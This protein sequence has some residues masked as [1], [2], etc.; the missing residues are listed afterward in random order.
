VSA[1]RKAASREEALAELSASFKGMQ[2]AYRRLRGRETQ[3]HDALSLAQ[4]QLLFGLVDRD[5]SA[6]DL[7]AAADLSPATVTQMLDYLVELGLVERAR[8]EH[9]RR[10]VLS[11]LT[12][13][14][15]SAVAERREHH[16]RRWREAL[17]DLDLDEL[18]A[19]AVVLDRLHEL[20]DGYSVTE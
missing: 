7:A 2:A 9:D 3:R 13:Q 10:V 1:A 16:L 14:G 8:A 12:E 4:S 20:F 18:R 6:G 15:R 17:D 19:A 11:R 5:L